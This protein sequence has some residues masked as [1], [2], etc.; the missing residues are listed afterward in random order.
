VADNIEIRD[1]T[2]ITTQQDSSCAVEIIYA[3]GF[4]LEQK[5]LAE[6]FQA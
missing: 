5:I 3:K 2:Q 4:N 6:Q 1:A